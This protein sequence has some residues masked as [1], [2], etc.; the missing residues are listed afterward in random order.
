MV[1]E[2][3]VSFQV[4]TPSFSY[5][6]RFP[7]STLTPHSPLSLP[8]VEEESSLPPS[9]L[10][11]SSRGCC[12]EKRGGGYERQSPAGKKTGGRAKET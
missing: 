5:L 1:Q 3:K 6:A 10:L 2:G 11:T 12:L 8:K 9:L 7:V 4:S